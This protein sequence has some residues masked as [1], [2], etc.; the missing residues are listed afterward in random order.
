MLIELIF[1]EVMLCYFC[2]EI[3]ER[4]MKR[5]KEIEADE[6]YVIRILL[7]LWNNETKV[8]KQEKEFGCLIK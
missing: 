1:E 6:E 2:N 3:I 5:E 8:N 7:Y 4:L